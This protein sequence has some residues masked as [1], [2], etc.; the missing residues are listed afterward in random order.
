MFHFEQELNHQKKETKSK[1]TLEIMGNFMNQ[2]EKKIQKLSS[3]RFTC[4]RSSQW[5]TDCVGVGVAFLHLQSKIH[6]LTIE[7]DL[8]QLPEL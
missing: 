5:W 6:C 7:K 4:S 2:N 1:S 3:G 8:L